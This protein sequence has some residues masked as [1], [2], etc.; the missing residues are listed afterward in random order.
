VVAPLA[1]ARFAGRPKIAYRLSACEAPLVTNHH[2]G[3]RRPTIVSE[4]D[5]GPVAFAMIAKI[6][7][8][9]RPTKNLSLY[10]SLLKLQPIASLILA[11]LRTAHEKGQ[12]IGLFTESTPYAP[13]S[14][15]SASKASSDLLVRAWRET[16]DLPTLVTNFSNN[17]GPH[18]FP[19][20]LIP[21]IIIK[22]LAGEPLP[23]YGDGLNVRDWLYVEDNVAID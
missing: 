17:Y 9:F 23:V 18:H 6:C 2:A 15:Y 4:I 21:H 22:G 19:E 14:S 16:Y 11:T 8:P 5:L 7:I 13:N 10:I 1:R 3:P 20:K 12:N